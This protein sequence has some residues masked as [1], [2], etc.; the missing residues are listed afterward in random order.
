MASRV[1]GPDFQ[2]WTLFSLL[3]PPFLH[4]LRL[5]CV[6]GNLGNEAILITDNDEVFALGSNGAGCLGLGDMSSTLEP[7]KVE[8][9]SGKVHRS[10]GYS[11]AGSPHPGEVK[12]LGYPIGEG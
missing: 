6:F 12:S 2:P 10:E 1:G 7:K 11:I 9:L 4:S 8:A 5:C 3:E